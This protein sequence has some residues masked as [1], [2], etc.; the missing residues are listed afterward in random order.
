MNQSELTA[1]QDEPACAHNNKAKSGCA[2]P[3][4]GATQGGCAFDGAR[5]ALLPIADGL[6]LAFAVTRYDGRLVISP[7]ACR[8]LLPDP[9]AFALC[10]RDS[11][12]DYLALAAARAPS[13]R[14]AGKRPATQPP[15]A[16]KPR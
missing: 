2:R 15:A 1:M 12:Q 7:T 8:E 14:P 6:G 5:N 10:L 13:R 11:F 16:G 4:P 3:Q 9:E